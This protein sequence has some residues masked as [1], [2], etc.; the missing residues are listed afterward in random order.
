VRAWRI[1]AALATFA[2]MAGLVTSFTRAAWLGMAMSLVVIV[3]LTRARWLIVLPV[4]LAGLFVLPGDFGARLRSAVDPAHAVN[5]ER[6]L[7]WDAGVR[8]FRD[9]PVT[10]V[11]LVDLGP[12]L[13]RYRSPEAVEPT[14]HLHDSYLQVAVTTGVVG[15]AAFAL[16]SVALMRAASRGVRVAVRGG[17]L[18]AGVRL[19]VTAG[20]AGFLVAALFDH[21]FGD[22]TL[23]A[24]L[25]TLAGIAWAARHWEAPA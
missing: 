10:G 24:M 12:F 6:M 9:H 17:G 25:F 2:T 20:A 18:A 23:I 7:M 16:L 4:A 13:E 5:R 15:F 19:G 14:R 1:G 21:A 22:R 11:G 3:G 8:I